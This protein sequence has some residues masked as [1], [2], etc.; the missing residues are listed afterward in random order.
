M[1]TSEDNQD[2]KNLFSSQREATDKIKTTPKTME[3]LAG[4]ADIIHEV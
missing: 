3:I 2:L 1:S 4:N